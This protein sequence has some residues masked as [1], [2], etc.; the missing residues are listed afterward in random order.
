MWKRRRRY[1]DYMRY[2]SQLF[3]NEKQYYG[4]FAAGKPYVKSN[5]QVDDFMMPYSYRPPKPPSWSPYR[6]YPNPYKQ[7]PQLK[8]YDNTV[9]DVQQTST[10]IVPRE[11]AEPSMKLYQPGY[12]RHLAAFK[13]SANLIKNYKQLLKNTKLRK[14]LHN[15][16]WGKLDHEYKRIDKI[17]AADPFVTR[18]ELPPMEGRTIEE[19]YRDVPDKE[20]ARL[21]TY[22]DGDTMTVAQAIE[23]ERRESGQ[24]REVYDVDAL[25]EHKQIVQGYRNDRRNN[26]LEYKRDL[27]LYNDKKAGEIEEHKQMVINNI[28]KEFTGKRFNKREFINVLE[29]WNN[30]HIQ[31]YGVPVSAQKI[32]E[33]YKIDL[34]PGV[35]YNIDLNHYKQF[36]GKLEN[37]QSKLALE[38]APRQPIIEEPEIPVIKNPSVPK[39]TYKS[40]DGKVADSSRSDKGPKL[41]LD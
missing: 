32:Q 20:H 39:L 17:M 36:V 12:E 37:G 1:N 9:S 22:R 31:A 27:A 19:A 29:R 11:Y 13:K 35:A 38:N 21:I 23:D 34:P 40:D 30:A 10:A 25:D 3:D 2:P 15:K 14:E 5:W 26:A 16:I 28:T 4:G 6:K 8:K 41:L 18:K 24:T 7:K 33:Y